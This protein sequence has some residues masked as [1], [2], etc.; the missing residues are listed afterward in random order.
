MVV[1][2][3][4]L[5]ALIMCSYCNLKAYLLYAKMNNNGTT[6]IMLYSSCPYHLGNWLPYRITYVYYCKHYD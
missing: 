4:V 2:D 5:I 1:I 3:N 6:W